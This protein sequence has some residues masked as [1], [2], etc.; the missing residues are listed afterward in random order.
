[1]LLEF[2]N[3]CKERNP[4]HL[5]T[6]NPG[7]GSELA[8]GTSEWTGRRALWPGRG[9]AISPVTPSAEPCTSAPGQLLSLFRSPLRLPDGNRRPPTSDHHCPPPRKK[10]PHSRQGWGGLGDWVGGGWGWRRGWGVRFVEPEAHTFLGPLQEKGHKIRD[11]T[12]EIKVNIRMRKKQ[13]QQ[14][15]RFKKLT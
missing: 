1:M 8:A 4:T 7:D 13:W 12:L 10:K 9:R 14:I 3:R 2:W 5:S 11:I 6:W 15:T